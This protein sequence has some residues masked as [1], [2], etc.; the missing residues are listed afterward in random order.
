MDLTVL[1]VEDDQLTRNSLRR[2]LAGRGYRVL[3]AATAEGARELCR[4]GG[5]PIDVALC[6]VMLPDAH[7]LLV[8]AELRA[9]RPS[10]RVILMSGYADYTMVREQS[11]ALGIALLEK[12]F[13][14]ADL[15]L[16]IKSALAA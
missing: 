13:S 3:E 7:G 16:R 10:L 5:E 4:H 12:P 14:N 11:V 2:V 8:A 9:L 15:T 1:I 6:D